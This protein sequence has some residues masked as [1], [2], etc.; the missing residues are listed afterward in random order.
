MKTLKLLFNTGQNDHFQQ[1]VSLFQSIE[2][3][4]KIPRKQVAKKNAPEGKSG[5]LY[6]KMYLLENQASA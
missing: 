5:A 3:L 1:Y 4:I 6:N 2:I